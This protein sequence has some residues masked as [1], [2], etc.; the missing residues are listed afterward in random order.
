MNFLTA[1][2]E[3]LLFA[4]YSVEPEVLKP[5]VPHGTSIDV[6]E[7]H[8]LL[9]LVGFMF[10]D[11]R[12]LGLPIPFHKSFEEVNL[13][14][15]VTPDH[16]RS[17][18]AVTF[19]REFAPKWIVA[20]VANFFFHEK[21]VAKSMTNEHSEDWHRYTWNSSRTNSISGKIVGELSLPVSG[22]IGE[23]IIEHYWGYTQTPQ[24]TLEY[25]VVHPQWQI[26]EIEDFEIEVDFATTYGSEFA[27]LR[28]QRPM[29]VQYARGSA[30][31]VSFPRRLQDCSERHCQCE[32]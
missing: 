29:N 30:V 15:Y 21:Y 28:Q 18:R 12:V 4:N 2:W 24:C 17:K 16:D 19:I 25:Y 9:S 5:F 11:A 8:V 23:F 20:A 7:G 10:N 13:R 3:H 31:E 1:R 32:F 27:F 6:F 22:S 26:S 14:F